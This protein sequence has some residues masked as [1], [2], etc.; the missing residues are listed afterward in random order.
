MDAPAAPSLSLS[1]PTGNIPPREPSTISS[2]DMCCT[3]VHWGWSN[4]CP[5]GPQ[6][7]PLHPNRKYPPTRAKYESTPRV[8]SHNATSNPIIVQNTAA[9]PPVYSAVQRVYNSGEEQDSPSSLVSG[10]AA[11]TRT[12]GVEMQLMQVGVRL[13]TAGPPSPPSHSK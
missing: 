8:K 11:A 2:R 10:L 13:S 7:V 12:S 5:G 9:L 4:G 3:A 1:T 6:L